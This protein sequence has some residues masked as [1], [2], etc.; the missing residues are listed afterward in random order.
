MYV[1]YFFIFSTEDNYI[2]NIKFNV[3]MKKSLSVLLIFALLFCAVLPC[4]AAQAGNTYYV[5][6]ENGDNGWDGSCAVHVDGTDQGPRQSL[7]SVMALTVSG[8]VVY[9]LPGVYSNDTMTATEKNNGNADVSVRC[10]VVVKAGVQLISTEG[11]EKT[12]IVGEADPD[13]PL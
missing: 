8:D 13:E 10:R 9:A 1:K 6:A 11:A 4:Y 3:H 12:V 5:D 2:C 7:A